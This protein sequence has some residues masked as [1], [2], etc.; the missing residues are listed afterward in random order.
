MSGATAPGAT[1]ASEAP[2]NIVVIT[3]TAAPAT[4][5]TVTPEDTELR[6]ALGSP[7]KFFAKS[8]VGSRVPSAVIV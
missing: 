8:P 4:V 7:R 3:T 6:Y 2:A 5:C 1:E